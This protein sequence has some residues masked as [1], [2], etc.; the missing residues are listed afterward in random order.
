[1][2]ILSASGETWLK[3]SNT[4][5]SAVTEDLDKTMLQAALK[6]HAAN[7]DVFDMFSPLPYRDSVSAMT[8]TRIY[9]VNNPAS[10]LKEIRSSGVAVYHWA[11]WKDMFPRDALLWYSNLTNPQKIAIGPWA[12]PELG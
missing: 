2:M 10:Y 11:G 8:G 1:M 7:L 6:D 5:G 4:D 3:S 12:H 9:D